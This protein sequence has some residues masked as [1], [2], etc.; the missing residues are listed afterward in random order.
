[1]I[2]LASAPTMSPIIIQAMI[3]PVTQPSFLEGCLGSDVYPQ[4]KPLETFSPSF[5]RGGRACY[6]DGRNPFSYM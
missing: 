5:R 4:V 1:M 3:E 6:L 2:N